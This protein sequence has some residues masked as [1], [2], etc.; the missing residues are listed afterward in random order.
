VL[1][2]S[3]I[4]W[5]VDGRKNYTGPQVQIE[6]HVLF[7]AKSPLNLAGPGAMQERGSLDKDGLE[8]KH[9]SKFVADDA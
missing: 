6:D 2:I 4:Q 7:A 3:M 9:S 1:I 5:F 8:D